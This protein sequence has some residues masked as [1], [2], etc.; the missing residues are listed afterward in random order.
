M[1]L[2]PTCSAPA[3]EFRH[4]LILLHAEARTADGEDESNGVLGEGL[5]GL[6][7]N[8]WRHLG[9]LEGEAGCLRWVRDARVL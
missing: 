5:I 4:H 7:L 2:I 8:L 6:D 3:A 9:C 1:M